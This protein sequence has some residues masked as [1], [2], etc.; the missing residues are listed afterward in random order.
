VV[1]SGRLTWGGP[2]T[3]PIV[4]VCSPTVSGCYHCYRTQ[5]SLSMDGPELGP[6]H[7]A[8]SQ[9]DQRVAALERRRRAPMPQHH[10]M[11]LLPITGLATDPFTSASRQDTIRRFLRVSQREA[12]IRAGFLAPRQVVTSAAMANQ[13]QRVHGEHGAV[14]RGAD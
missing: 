13:V 4:F 7:P 2:T 3:R 1:S 11:L 8:T 12:S 10:L 9:R 5:R 14:V 6:G